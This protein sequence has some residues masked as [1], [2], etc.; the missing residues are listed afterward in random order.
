MAR[1]TFSP[2]STNNSCGCGTNGSS[3]PGTAF[4]S[5]SSPV[6]TVS[7]YGG[8]AMVAR[9]ACRPTQCPSPPVSEVPER[10]PYCAGWVDKVTTKAAGMLTLFLE[11]CI[12]KLWS[13]CSGFVYYDR[14]TEQVSVQDPKFVSSIPKESS[15]GFLAKV[16]PTVHTVCVDGQDNCQTEIRQELAA[17]LLGEASCGRLLIGN[18]PLCGDVPVAQSADLDK[19]VHVDYLDAPDHEDLGCPAGVR[20]LVKT[21]GVRGPSGRQVVCEQWSLMR[22]FVLRGSDW[23]TLPAGSPLEAT[24]YIPVLVPV[25][26]GVEN[27]PCFELRMSSQKLNQGLPTTAENCDTVV[28]EG[29]GTVDEGWKARPKGLSSHPTERTDLFTS[30]NTG[31]GALTLTPPEQPLNVCGDLYAELEIIIGTTAGP[32]GGQS[33]MLISN[34]ED[35]WVLGYSGDGT[36]VYSTQCKALM[37][38]GELHLMRNKIG[39]GTCSLFIRLIGYAY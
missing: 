34:T 23:G 29:K 7:S 3:P 9:G 17:Q 24:G 10:T 39:T 15:A 38:D 32:S 25:P 35:N 13:K 2:M 12:Y 6:G 11:G 1:P 8:N 20:F 30:N 19:Q 37:A 22:R 14:E 27:D 26:G 21:Q 31:T 16:V 28:F 5:V 18:S 36:G 4:P 33:R